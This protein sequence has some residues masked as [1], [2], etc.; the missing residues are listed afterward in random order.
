MTV[1]HLN[2]EPSNI[3]INP[4]SDMIRNPIIGSIARILPI[5]A[6]ENIIGYRYRLRE[7][8][9]NGETYYMKVAG[10]SMEAKISNG[11]DVLIRR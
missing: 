11:A 7:T 6:T 5:L 3:I 2:A 9:P 10:D 8:L 1:P 4:D